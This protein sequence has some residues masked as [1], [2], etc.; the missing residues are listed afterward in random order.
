ML[1]VVLAWAMPAWGQ[2]TMERWNGDTLTA[3]TTGT[4]ATAFYSVVTGGNGGQVVKIFSDFDLTGNSTQLRPSSNTT[5]A[6]AITWQGVVE[7]TAQ[8]TISN[9][10]RR[11][12]DYASGY[13]NFSNLR[14]YNCGYAF[15]AT[16]AS[17]NTDYGAIL[18]VGSGEPPMTVS[19]D[20]VTFESCFGSGAVFSTD[21]NIELSGTYSLLNNKSDNVRARYGAISAKNVLL[22]GD[23]S[24]GTFSGNGIYNS[25]ALDATRTEAIDIH[26]TGSTT[27]QGAGKYTLDGGIQA[28]SGLTIG[29]A[30]GSATNVTFKTGAINK[31]TG[32]ITI[33]SGA[34]VTYES[35][36]TQTVSGNLNNA[37]A[38]ITA[39]TLQNLAGTVATAT[40][41]GTDLVLNN[42]SDT[43]Y[44]GSV[45]GTTL[46]KTG[47]GRLNLSGTNNVTGQVTVSEGTLRIPLALGRSA[48]IAEGATLELSSAYTTA[49]TT[50]TLTITGSGN[51]ST[52]SEC[53]L[54]NPAGLDD[55]TGDIYVSG[56]TFGMKGTFGNTTSTIYLAGGVLR[57][58]DANSIYGND[59][60][61]NSASGGF[62]PGWANCTLTLN[63]KI[64]NGTHSTLYIQSDSNL[65]SIVLLTNPNNDYTDTIIQNGSLGGRLRITDSGALGTGTVTVTKAVRADPTQERTYLDLNGCD[66]VS[67]R[68]A[69]EGE[70]TNMNA[71]DRTDVV[72][73]SATLTNTYTGNIRFVKD[74]GTTTLSTGYAYTGGTEIRGGTLKLTETGSLG[75]GGLTLTGGTLELGTG[76]YDLGA[77]TGNGG[78]IL[79][80]VLSEESYSQLTAESISGDAA[81]ILDFSFD[82]DDFTV[83]R[84]SLFSNVPSLADGLDWD[85]LLAP[86]YRG[87]WNLTPNSAGGLTMGVDWSAAPEPASGVL[88]LLVFWGYAWQWR[89][90]NGSVHA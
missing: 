39:S 45:S 44:A 4:D 22:T 73:D 58:F 43:T 57:N 64:S 79:S 3:S 74:S 72:L 15:D 70:V 9:H 13:F 77:I 59:I 29:D 65:N 16:N 32:N 18:W 11:F 12:Y 53:W 41:S 36:V 86:E 35:G 52:V 2:N 5:Q 55:F 23:S 80:T 87:Y 88:L 28:G 26:S 83:S 10:T 60:V 49:S 30:S 62:R 42:T 38:I 48:H 85:L 17:R 27:I 20:N 75:T 33:Q 61:I 14:F 90:R 56:G 40:V 71:A 7:G 47:T 78:T 67:S 1:V 69:G 34:T 82:P 84:F 76:A 89:K 63:G 50:S 51:L 19:C 37:G 25:S 24:V 21:R 6:T 8:R 66:F 54:S 31:I 81:G 46:T 68:L